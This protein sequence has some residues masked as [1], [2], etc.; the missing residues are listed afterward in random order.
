MLGIAR[1]VGGPKAVRAVGSACADN[2]LP[3]VIPCHRVVRSDGAPVDY[4]GGPEAKM[5]LL[6]LEE[7]GRE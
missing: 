2:L 5:A 4:V 1:A 7:V 6:R 3:V